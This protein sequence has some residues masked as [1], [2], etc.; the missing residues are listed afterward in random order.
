M[1]IATH[2]RAI[3]GRYF[4]FARKLFTPDTLLTNDLPYDLT[5]PEVTWK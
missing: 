1:Q 3:T 2:I 5:D 4:W